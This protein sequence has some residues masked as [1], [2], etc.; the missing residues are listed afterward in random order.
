MNITVNGLNL[1]HQLIDWLI[2]QKFPY[3]I[4]ISYHDPFSQKYNVELTNPEHLFLTR[5][6][7]GM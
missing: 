6:K 5:L 4:N 1:M 2:E 3:K 7:W